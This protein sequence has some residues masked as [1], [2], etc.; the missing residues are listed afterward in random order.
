MKKEAAINFQLD[1]S[2]KRALET[3]AA[4]LVT[5]AERLA[6]QTEIQK[7]AVPSS[8]FSNTF[9]V[10]GP[11]GA[12]KST[13]LYQFYAACEQD[14]P[15]LPLKRENLRQLLVIPSLD[16]SVVPATLEPG[17]AMLLHLQRFLEKYLVKKPGIEQASALKDELK[18]LLSMYVR[19]SKEYHELCLDIAS[20]P[21]DF[22]DRVVDA[23]RERFEL[24][25][26]LGD[27]LKKTLEATDHRAIVMLLDDFDLIPADES[28]RW[29]GSL[30]DELHQHR[31]LFV[32]TADV[33]RLEHL[34]W[35][36]RAEM[37]DKTGRALLHKTIPSQNRIVLEPWSST[38]RREYPN[39]EGKETLS[40]RMRRF[41]DKY[42]ARGA[43]LLHLLP[44]WPRGV[45]NL[46]D[47]LPEVP[48]VEDVSEQKKDKN[49]DPDCREIRLFL[50]LLATCREEPLLA[51]RLDETDLSGW[52]EEL[53]FAKK[54]L[55]AEDWNATVEAAC[56]R[57]APEPG[58][59]HVLRG[60]EPLTAAGNDRGKPRP[61][62]E[63]V[64]FIPGLDTRG[65]SG[66]PSGPDPLRH[67]E[68]W[69]APLRDAHRQ[70]QPLWAE[71]LLNLGFVAWEGGGGEDAARNRVRFLESWKPAA[72]RLAEARLRLQ[73]SKEVLRELSERQHEDLSALLFWISSKSRRDPE[74][75]RVE[76]GWPPLLQA[77]RGERD[78][79][80]P[81]KLAELM[82]DL[83]DIHGDPPEI[84]SAA[85]LDLIPDQLWA[86]VLLIDGLDRCPWELFSAR[87]VLDVTIY[88]GLAGAFLHSAYAYAL[89]RTGTR[90][91]KKLKP[92]QDDLVGMLEK[93]N[94]RPWR[95]LQ[96]DELAGKVQ[97]FFRENPGLGQGDDSLSRAARSFLDS[98]VY[99]ALRSFVLD[100]EHGG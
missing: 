11:R 62:R 27:W 33:H 88:L 66:I 54:A 69:A 63:L 23:A 28:R 38:A 4:K 46:Y 86:M 12:G 70:D 30:L 13:V 3:L 58:E 92:V 24:K 73:L 90:G 75:A 83:S 21:Q 51:R 2:Q 95:A 9:G 5:A 60:L 71:L 52:V 18:R 39:Q 72:S 78:P 68:L 98:K 40:Q 100:Q 99:R 48:L 17:S 64:V 74:N 20:S 94:P 43:L 97:E 26:A 36:P 80:Q 96:E 65:G 45:V 85:V 34:A 57:V 84:G 47:S 25:D 44:R 15:D 32:L 81:K 56:E 42:P 22:G 89:R 49:A 59:L 16:C 1:E 37:D 53:R 77:L 93:R 41:F 29:L 61:R 82:I 35:D 8:E 91:T 7:R 67:G 31:L 87:R 6:H 19:T 79:L 14:R 50:S 55:S 10:F 76:I